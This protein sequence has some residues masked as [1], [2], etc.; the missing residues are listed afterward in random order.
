MFGG[1]TPLA[2]HDG[3][4]LIEFQTLFPLLPDS[5]PLTLPFT[6]LMLFH[7]KK[8]KSYRKRGRSEDSSGFKKNDPVQ[9]IRRQLL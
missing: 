3:L 4:I 1:V 6:F 9:G 7:Q 8:E 2:W 5:F